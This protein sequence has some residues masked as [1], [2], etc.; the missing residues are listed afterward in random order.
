LILDNNLDRIRNRTRNG[1]QGKGLPAAQVYGIRLSVGSIMS[2]PDPDA[3][4]GKGNRRI[5]RPAARAE[6]SS[7]H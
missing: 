6:D 3:L 2:F 5:G 4:P 7:L 1:K